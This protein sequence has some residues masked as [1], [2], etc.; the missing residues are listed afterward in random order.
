MMVCSALGIWRL[1]NIV[2]EDVGV[3]IMALTI[4]QMSTPRDV[5]ARCPVCPSCTCPL[6]PQKFEP[7][8]CRWAMATFQHPSPGTLAASQEEGKVCYTET[9]MISLKNESPRIK[10]A[11]N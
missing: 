4:L 7:H 5:E 3:L 6:L 10:V 9:F 1:Q 8:C 2:E 11:A